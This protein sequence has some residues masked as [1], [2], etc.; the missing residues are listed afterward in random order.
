M[1]GVLTGRV[2][3]EMQPRREFHGKRTAQIFLQNK[4]PALQ[5]FLRLLFVLAHDGK[6][7]IG[8]VHV[9]RDID[10][11]DSQKPGEFI[12]FLMDKYGSVSFVDFCRQLR[13]GKSLQDA[14]G[15]AYSTY[16]IRTL[17]DL[18]DRL[19]EHLEEEK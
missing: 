15:A 1:I 13:D 14:L 17:Q 7:N 18:E 16:S 5:N 11:F 12:G 8:V 6:I 3:D 2:V 9:G 4:F 10:F 19:I